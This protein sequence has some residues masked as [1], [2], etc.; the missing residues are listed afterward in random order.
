V[1][2]A[3]EAGEAM[4]TTARAAA[5]TAAGTALLWVLIFF[6]SF[7]NVVTSKEAAARVKAPYGG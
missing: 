4:V 7:P 2:D 3:A 1:A 6:R 5:V